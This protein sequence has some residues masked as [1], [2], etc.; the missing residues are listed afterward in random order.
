VLGAAAIVAGLSILGSIAIVV[1]RSKLELSGGGMQALTI[2]LNELGIGA[3]LGPV[4]L[5]VVIGVIESLTAW[6]VVPAN[7]MSAVAEEGYLPAWM[8]RASPKGAPCSCCRGPGD[9]PHCPSS[10][11]KTS[12]LIY[13]MVTASVAQTFVVMYLLTYAS[14]FWFQRTH[15][16]ARR[17]FKIPGGEPSLY[18]VVGLGA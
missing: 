12:T 10:F 4:G 14:L 2:S 11:V 8:A 18:L 1:S 16:D 7:G 3:L 17:P 15:P 9:R 13:W 5:V 6:A